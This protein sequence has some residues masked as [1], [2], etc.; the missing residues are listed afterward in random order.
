[1]GLRLAGCWNLCHIWLTKTGPKSLDLLELEGKMLINALRSGLSTRGNGIWDYSYWFTNGS[2]LAPGYHWILCQS[3]LDPKFCWPWPTKWVKMS[4]STPSSRSLQFIWVH[5][6]WELGPLTNFNRSSWEWLKELFREMLI[7]QNWFSISTSFLLANSYG[8]HPPTH[9]SL[10]STSCE[11]GLV[12]GTQTAQISKKVWPLFLRTLESMSRKS[13]CSTHAEDQP[14]HFFCVQVSLP[15]SSVTRGYDTIWFKL[16]SICLFW[17]KKS[18]FLLY[19][20]LTLKI[21]TIAI[22]SILRMTR[23]K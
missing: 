20:I 9:L 3:T 4:Y 13:L 10:L 19:Q 14:A 8:I 18:V 23:G 6:F 17:F 16:P 11:P 5:V 1:M 2:S 15:F 21:Q 22:L 12:L 7:L